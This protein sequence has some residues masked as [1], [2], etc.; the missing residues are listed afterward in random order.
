MQNLKEKR[1][2]RSK[3]TRKRIA[4]I[5]VIQQALTHFLIILKP[6]S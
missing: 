2:R 3:E 4:Q 1:I 6:H 5:G